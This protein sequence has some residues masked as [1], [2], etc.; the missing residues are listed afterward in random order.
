MK[1]KNTI[2]GTPPQ[3]LVV[4]LPQRLQSLMQG[5]ASLG[6]SLLRQQ[7]VWHLVSGSV[8]VN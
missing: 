5:L 8:D 4:E 6:V 3:R 1:L 2:T 7:F